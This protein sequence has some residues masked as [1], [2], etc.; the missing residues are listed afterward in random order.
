MA[1]MGQLANGHV[2]ADVEFRANGGVPSP[3]PQFLKIHAAF[4]K[5]LARSQAAAYMDRVEISNQR[6][7]PTDPKA[8]DDFAT[9]LRYK[10][11]ASAP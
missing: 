11:Q 3:N 9:L 6:G 1:R 2:T 7:A 10:L 4:A 8:E 5:V